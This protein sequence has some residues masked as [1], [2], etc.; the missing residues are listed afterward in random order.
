MLLLVECALLS[1]LDRVLLF[2][3]KPFHKPTELLPG[4][5]LEFIL[6]TGPL[7]LTVLKPLVQENESVLLPHE[8]FDA[9][10]PSATEQE[11]GRFIRI[12]VEM[13]SD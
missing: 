11:Q 4:Y 6:C 10:R 12:H 13:L 7:K 8:R 9:V 2:Y 1:R 3:L 5:G